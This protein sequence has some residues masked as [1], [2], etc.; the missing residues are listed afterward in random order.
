LTLRLL[1]F[2]LG[3]S[4]ILYITRAGNGHAVRREAH[5][6]LSAVQHGL[7][8]GLPSDH[9]PACAAQ[10]DRAGAYVPALLW[11]TGASI[12]ASIIGSILFEAARPG[13]G[14]QRDVRDQ[15]IYRFGEY[16]SRWFIV[17]GA[18]AGM[19]M[20]MARWDYFWIA[21][22]IYLG[23]TPCGPSVAQ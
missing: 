13:A 21:N 18:A 1:C 23:F 16:A 17:A 22:V 7:L 4:K 9:Q 19:L 8:R 11:A 10:P 5:L 2:T 6:G 14:R 20:A 3:L 15:E 12:L